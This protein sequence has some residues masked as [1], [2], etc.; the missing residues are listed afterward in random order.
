MPSRSEISDLVFFPIHVLLIDIMESFSII[1]RLTLYFLERGLSYQ[2]ASDYAY[3]IIF[4]LIIL[5][6]IILIRIAIALYKNP[7]EWDNIDWNL[8]ISFLFVIIL[9]ILV[10]YVI[11]HFIIKYW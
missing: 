1:D 4:G 2:D 9:I 10:I 8:A 6:S 7:P 11:L 3:L 5:G